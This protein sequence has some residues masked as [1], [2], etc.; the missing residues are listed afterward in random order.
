MSSRRR[1]SRGFAGVEVG[2]KLICFSRCVRGFGGT[3]GEEWHSAVFL[4]L[5]GRQRAPPRSVSVSL[6]CTYCTILLR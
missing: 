4:M 3:N 6:D 1:D 5:L 2:E